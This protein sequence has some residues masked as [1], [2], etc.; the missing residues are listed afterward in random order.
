MPT[1]HSAQPSA[2]SAGAGPAGP[3]GAPAF[4]VSDPASTEALGRWLAAQ[5]GEQPLD[6]VLVQDDLPSLVLGHV[7]ARELGVGLIYAFDDGGLLQASGA[8]GPGSGV[9]LVSGE[10]LEDT[11]V[12]A[13]ASLLER[14]DSRLAVV[15]A[16]GRGE[17]EPGDGPSA[18]EEPG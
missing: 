8:I 6:A 7:V 2:T 13:A 16:P 9:G 17:V 5:V 14:H 4:D 3:P 1:D 12:R 10:P 11:S 18:T 15:L